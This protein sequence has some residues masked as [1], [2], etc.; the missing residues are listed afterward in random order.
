[1]SQEKI[2]QKPEPNPDLEE[3]PTKELLDE[4]LSRFDSAIF[5]GT[6]ERDSSR[7]LYHRRWFGNLMECVGLAT[8]MQTTVLDDFTSDCEDACE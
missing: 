8:Y 3:Y 7:S 6:S 2:N 5:C 1:M 4:I